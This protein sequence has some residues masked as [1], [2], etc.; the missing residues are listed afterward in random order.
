MRQTWTFVQRSTVAAPPASVWARVVTP[1]GINDEL[2]PWMTMS[3]P[4]GAG[5]VT[6]DTLDVGMPIGR[7]WLR[8]LGVVPFDYDDLC[9]SLVEHGHRFREESTMASMRRWV[10]DR[11]VTAGPDGGSQVVDVVTFSPRW[12]FRPLGGL[13]RVVLA[14]LFRHR[15]RRLVRHFAAGTSI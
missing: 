4:R 14:A 9:V 12:A 1:E 8:L 5:G 7:A 11:T 10:H 13:L 2:R 3:L 15:H 6:I